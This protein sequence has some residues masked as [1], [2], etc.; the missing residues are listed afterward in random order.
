MSGK[1]R[2]RCGYSPTTVNALRL[3]VEHP[4]WYLCAH[5]YVRDSCDRPVW[6]AIVENPYASELGRIRVMTV[7]T[8]TFRVMLREQLLAEIGSHST[9]AVNG[10][11]HVV[12]TYRPSY[13]GA[14]I[15]G[16]KEVTS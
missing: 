16:K 5:H 15:G 4:D 1:V 2:A 7:P 10:Q 6:S 12:T 13:A 9:D 3:L 11:R 8:P 14:I